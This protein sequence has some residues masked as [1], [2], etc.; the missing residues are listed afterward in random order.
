MSQQIYSGAKC[1]HVDSNGQERY[2]VCNCE[3]WIDGKA[4]YGTGEGTTLEYARVNAE[5]NLK[6]TVNNY[7]N[8]SKTSKT[9]YENGFNPKTLISKDLLNGGGNKPISEKQLNLI[10]D[11]ATQKS[12]NAE[13]MSEEKFHKSLKDLTGGEADILIKQ[14]LLKE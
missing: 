11:K 12:K 4:F 2:V 13:N 10:K 9:E 14:L 1:V 5:E 6:T 3:A 7:L 8:K